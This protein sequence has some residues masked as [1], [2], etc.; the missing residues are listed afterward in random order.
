MNYEEEL[1]QLMDQ[2]YE[3]VGDQ[4]YVRRILLEF[5][6]RAYAEGLQDGRAY[7]ESCYED[8]EDE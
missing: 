5:S 8:E 3:N 7:S 2:I 6:N 4:D 1:D